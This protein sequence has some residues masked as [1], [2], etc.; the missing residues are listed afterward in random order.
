MRNLYMGA[1]LLFFL[2]SCD[3]VSDMEANIENLTT[4]TLT[5]EFV[6]SI[7]DLSKTL[8]IKPNEIELFQEGFDVGGTFLEP[9][10]V[11]YDSVVVMDQQQQVL[12]VYKENDNGKNIYNVTEYWM[13]SE[14]SKR[15]FKY[16]YE[17]NTQDIE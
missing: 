16:E 11:E 1:T 3:P 12:R 14:P 4:Q 13:G 17:I 7:A 15:F 2:S 6:S 5:V 10:L 8:E 9:S